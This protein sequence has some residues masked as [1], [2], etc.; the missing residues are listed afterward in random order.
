MKKQRPP[1]P[2]L[3]DRLSGIL[4]DGTW[5]EKA[6]YDKRRS[7]CGHLFQVIRTDQ[8]NRALSFENAAFQASVVQDDRSGGERF[9]IKA[10]I[11]EAGQ[12]AE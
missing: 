2:E 5:L 3:V 8:R 9:Q 11:T 12:R 1:V 4:P 6:V 7:A 10:D